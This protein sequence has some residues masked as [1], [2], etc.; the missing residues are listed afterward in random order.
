MPLYKPQ[1]V[2]TPVLSQYS[3]KGKIAAVT[4]GAGGIGLEVV[5]GIAEAGA[6]VAM[7]YNTSADAPEMAAMI[8]K[9]TGCRIHAFQSTIVSRDAIANTLD[10]VAKE[11][12]RLDVVVAN[13]GF[14]ASIPSLEYDEESWQKDREVNLDGTMWTAQAAGRIF[15]RQ[16]KGNL[17]VTASV[18]SITVNIPQRQ[19]AYN[20]SKAAIV[21]LA[22][23]LAVEWID[24]A[25]VNCISPGYIDTEMLRRQPKELF[26]KWLSM[27][28]GN[29]LCE[30]AELKSVSE[31]SAT[32]TD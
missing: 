19:A 2:H 13:A 6:D 24:F 30:A 12:G 31:A 11:F 21:H 10:K 28:P 5:R 9:E 16:G 4:G 1:N 29:R 20:A 22:K 26:E 18:S 25:R 8:A 27:I 7:I 14:C 15:E 23:T 3:L 32:T 17:I